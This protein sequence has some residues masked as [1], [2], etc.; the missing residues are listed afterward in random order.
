[1]FIVCQKKFGSFKSRKL[2]PESWAGLKDEA[3]KNETGVET[4]TFCH[5]GRFICCAKTK[6]DAIKLAE[7]AVNNK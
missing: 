3:L 1:M 2:F 5:N 4:A 6:E 7:I